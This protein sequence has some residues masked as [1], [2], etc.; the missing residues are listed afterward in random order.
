MYAGCSLKELIFFIPIMV[1]FLSNLG[2]S[3]QEILMLE[4]GFAAMLVLFE[5]PSGY[6]ADLYGRKKSLIIGSLLDFLGM[7]I[8]IFSSSFEGFFIGEI[9]LGIGSSFC[10]GAEEALIYET[11]LEVKENSRY[12]KI[13]GNMY[14]YARIASTFSSI[15]GAL[16]AA[17]FL[18]LPFYAT[19]VPWALWVGINFTLV[20]PK[21]HKKSFEK[22]GHFV[23][24]C[25][26]SFVDNKKLRYFLIY[27]AIPP[28]FFMM[29][30]WLYQRYM[31][32]V[33]LPIF[34]FG[35]VIAAMNIFSGLGSKYAKEIEEKL[36]PKI[37][38]II[39]PVL[40]VIVWSVFAGVKSLWILP[41]VLVTGP[42][43]GFVG[44]IIND[45]IHKIVSSDRRAT[46]LSIRSFLSRGIF[47][48]LAPFLGFVTDVYS[49]QMAFAAAAVTLFALTAVSFVSLKMV[50]IL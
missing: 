16:L 14:F 49:I 13:Q 19:L 26:E 38:L 25:K 4:S 9:I 5:I 36:T 18:R 41:L 30:F 32:F 39:I 3:M 15:T 47:L 48:V 42:L 28:G 46:V 50:K 11:L 6:F 27:S 29:S 12:K 24:I 37:S 44:V 45:F 7:T 22:W 31:G 2:L 40:S 33:E 43:W 10:S 23:K 20:E 1:P 8:F 21:E 17:V 34:Y 35:F